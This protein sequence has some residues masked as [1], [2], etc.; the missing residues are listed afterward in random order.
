MIQVPYGMTERVSW[1]WLG[2]PMNRS[3]NRNRT[4]ASGLTLSRPFS[5]VLKYVDAGGVP[6]TEDA[7]HK[8]MSASVYPRASKELVQ[9]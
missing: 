5:A 9:V 7:I 4:S 3:G 8:C 6:K 1:L 2:T